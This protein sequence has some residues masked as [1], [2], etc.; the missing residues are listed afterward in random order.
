MAGLSRR[1]WR[2]QTLHQPICRRLPL[3][4]RC[5]GVE[6]ARPGAPR[7][8]DT[9]HGRSRRISSGEPRRHP[10]LSGHPR[11]APWSAGSAGSTPRSAWRISSLRL[12][13]S[14]ATAPRSVCRGRRSRRVHAG[15]C[16]G[17]Q[18]LGGR[19]LGF[20]L[21]GLPGRPGRRTRA[22]VGDGHFRLAVARRGHAACHR[23]GWRGRRCPSL[24]RPTTVRCSR[25]STVYRACSFRTNRRETWRPRLKVWRRALLR[26][27]LGKALRDT[28]EKTYSA[29]VVVPQWESLFEAV[30]TERVAS[31]E[32]SVFNSFIQGGFECSTSPVA[33]RFHFSSGTTV[34]C[35]G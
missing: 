11:Q 24:P 34:T 15:I 16:R 4:P 18:K 28:V 32:P 8:R 3:D 35:T 2:A 7:D 6:D 13:S 17:A 19:G 27:R 14:A 20:R 5:S 12:R 33:T 25:S 9:L 21:L 10:R 1:R 29:D 26:R 31:P 23:R 30:L 22:S